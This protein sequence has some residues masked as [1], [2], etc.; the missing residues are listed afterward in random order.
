[1]IVVFLDWIYIA[2]ILTFVGIL[3]NRIVK[4]ETSSLTQ[5]IVTGLVAVTAFTQWVSIF[6]KIGLV[7]HIFLLIVC[8]ATAYIERDKCRKLVKG[9]KSGQGR[10]RASI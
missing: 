6:Y 8:G 7:V 5:I 10:Q 2:L 1:M 9:Q 3:V 4:K